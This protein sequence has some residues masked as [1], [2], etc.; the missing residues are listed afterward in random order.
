MKK[1]LLTALIAALTVPVFALPTVKMDVADG[2]H[3]YTAQVMSGTVG[4]YGTADP[5]FGTFCIERNEHFR[6]GRTYEVTIEKIAMYNNHDYSRGYEGD[7]IFGDP[8]DDETAY[9][10]TEYLKNPT[11]FDAAAMQDAIWYSEEELTSISGVA[12]TYYNAAVAA[13][14]YSGGTWEGIGNVRVM[15]L[16]ERG[17]GEAPYSPKSVVQSQL[18]T[19]PVPG[20]FLLGGIGVT[21]VGW[22]KRRRNL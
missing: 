18:V 14:T 17:T 5:A 7:P 15:N 9:L 3:P 10:Y 12:L 20:A 19:V 1:L 13:Q 6:P 21:C 2:G 11:T 22:M 8:L 4:I 16:W